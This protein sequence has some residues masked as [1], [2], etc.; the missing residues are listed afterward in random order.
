MS[1][2]QLDYTFLELWSEGSAVMTRK[3]GKR[4]KLILIMKVFFTL[5]VTFSRENLIVISLRMLQLTVIIKPVSVRLYCTYGY[6]LH[7][8]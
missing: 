4:K 6:L 3:E 2:V 5:Y 7:I 1:I 8:L